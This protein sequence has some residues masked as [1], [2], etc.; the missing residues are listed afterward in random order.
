VVTCEMKLFQRF[1]S[2]ATTVV[3]CEIKRW[4]YFKIISK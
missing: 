1:I 4:N 2:H 3:T